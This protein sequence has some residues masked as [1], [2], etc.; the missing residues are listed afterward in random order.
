MVRGDVALG[1]REKARQPGLG[2][3]QVVVAGI[4]RALVDSVPDREQPAGGVEQEAEVHL[5]EELLGLIGD[6]REAAGELRGSAR[7]RAGLG[8]RRIGQLGER[9]QGRRRAG[10]REQREISG[11]ARHGQPDR[12]GPRHELGFRAIT[13]LGGDGG[14]DIR[15]R[16]RLRRELAQVRRPVGRCLRDASRRPRQAARG[17]RR[18]CA[19]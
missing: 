19:G 6:R 18:G 10:S 13:A 8:I 17:P 16:P 4:E 14:D 2:R 7:I 12:L 9:R 5:R 3:Q 11:M 1:D 15:E